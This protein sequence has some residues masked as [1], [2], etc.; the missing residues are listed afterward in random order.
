[1]KDEASI[2][3][4][5]F[6]GKGISPLSFTA[7]ELGELLIDLQKGMSAFAEFFGDED[8]KDSDQTLS[9]VSIENKSSS[10]SFASYY[11]SALEGY[12][13][14]IKSAKNKNLYGLPRDAFDGLKTISKLAKK[15]NCNAELSSEQDSEK[16][17][18]VITPEDT[19]I[20]PEEVYMRD[21]KDFYGEITRVGGVKPKVR[22]RTFGGSVLNGIATKKLAKEIAGMLY[23]TVKLKAEIKWLASSSEIEEIKILDV[24]EFEVQSNS[25]LFDDLRDSLGDYSEK[26]GSDLKG[27]IN[28]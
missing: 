23:Q 10:L 25:D 18:A 5:R 8:W 9:L 13:L 17:Y 19:L 20:I 4:I 28:D 14:M 1:L 6:S 27:L 22:F 3:K 15:K 21:T 12:N 11:P 16:K 24:E 26:Y 7:K 2:L